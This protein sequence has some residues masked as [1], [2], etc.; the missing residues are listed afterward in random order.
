MAF[1]GYLGCLEGLKVL[2]LANWTE[3]L[4]FLTLVPCVPLTTFF[5]ITLALRTARGAVRLGAAGL[6]PSSPAFFSA[7]GFLGAG[8]LGAAFESFPEKQFILNTLNSSRPPLTNL[9]VLNHSSK[10]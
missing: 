2:G 6:P 3:V 5:W 1:L 8:F 7:A 4:T 9:R 10:L